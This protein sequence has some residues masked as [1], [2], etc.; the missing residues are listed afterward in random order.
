MECLSKPSDQTNFPTF[1]IEEFFPQLQA[2]KYKLALHIEEVQ[3][4]I[5]KL[6]EY[7]GIS[8]SLLHWYEIIQARLMKINESNMNKNRYALLN[9]LEEIQ[10]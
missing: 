7:D 1:E 10:V 5:N 2:L 3:L 8:I 6:L 4:L 9:N